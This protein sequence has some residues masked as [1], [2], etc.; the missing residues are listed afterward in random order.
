MESYKLLQPWVDMRIGFMIRL[1][2]F[3][4]DLRIEKKRATK[5]RFLITRYKLFYDVF[6]F[7]IHIK[8]PTI[9]GFV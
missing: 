7:S 4:F 6:I 2:I 5:A 9:V 8:N 3:I 1:F